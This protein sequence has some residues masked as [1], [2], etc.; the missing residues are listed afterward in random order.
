MF[1][2]LILLYLKLRV[3]LCR[4]HNCTYKLLLPIH[5]S[6]AISFRVVLVWRPL[7]WISHSSW[8]WI[9]MPIFAIYYSACLNMNTVFRTNSWV[10]YWRTL[11][12]L[13][14]WIWHTF[15]VVLIR[16]ILQVLHI[17]AV[18]IGCCS[19]RCR[20]LHYLRIVLIL[21]S[22]SHCWIMLVITT[23]TH[24]NLLIIA[25]HTLVLKLLLLVLLL[26]CWRTMK[27]MNWTT[28][29]CW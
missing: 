3:V 9:W 13:K 20:C 12:T 29:L 16:I 22:N 27:R 8:I 11:T 18:S 26:R 15:I 6:H 14:L 24:Q 2:C 5:Q 21:R 19:C 25:Y 7:N 23:I 1:T 4:T 28:S 17:Y 10:C